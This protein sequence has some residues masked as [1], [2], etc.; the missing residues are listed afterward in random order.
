[1]AIKD[2]LRARARQL[3]ALAL[4]LAATA[5]LIYQNI[6]PVEVKFT[7]VS[8]K[9]PRFALVLVGLGAGFLLGWLAGRR[10]RPPAPV[11]PRPEERERPPTVA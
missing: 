4:V 11:A 3:I 1:M 8:V 10:R 7:F 9:M 5:L 6:A 2:A